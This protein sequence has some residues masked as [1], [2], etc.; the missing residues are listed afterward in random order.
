MK[1]H[2]RK[3]TTF[4]FPTWMVP[5]ITRQSQETNRSRYIEECITHFCNF[6]KA[7]QPAIIPYK[8][9]ITTASLDP[10]ILKL[11]DEI[12]PLPTRSEMV[13]MAV[14]FDVLYHAINTINPEI[15]EQKLE[16]PPPMVEKYGG[17]WA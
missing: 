14:M 5:Y 13:R 17:D 10:T 9:Q 6:I 15:I 12:N 1:K 2:L 3:I 4:N 16:T 11:I 8:P 7:N